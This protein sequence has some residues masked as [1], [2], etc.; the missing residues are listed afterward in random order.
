MEQI[1]K[2]IGE[3]IKLVRIKHK[4]TRG[5]VAEAVNLSQQQIQKYELG[6]NRISLEKAHEVAEYLKID[7]VELIPSELRKCLN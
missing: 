3:H 1:N 2:I 7:I 5:D 4:K 6:V